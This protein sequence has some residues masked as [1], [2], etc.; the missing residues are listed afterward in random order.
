[1]QNKT[2]SLL[3]YIIGPLVFIMQS[4]VL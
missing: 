4:N 2:S 1:M 3:I